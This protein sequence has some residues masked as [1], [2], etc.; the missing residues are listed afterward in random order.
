MVL[1]LPQMRPGVNE[2]CA[3]TICTSPPRIVSYIVI[4]MGGCICETVLSIV[5]TS[6]LQLSVNLLF[7]LYIRFTKIACILN[8]LN[9]RDKCPNFL[10][11]QGTGPM[12]HEGNG[13]LSI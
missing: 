1:L 11:W 6:P 8:H 13:L 12:A 3:I 2:I 9:P 5:L 10:Q 4:G 7:F